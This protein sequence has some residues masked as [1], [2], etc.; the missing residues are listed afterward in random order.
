M[1]PTPRGPPGGGGPHLTEDVRTYHCY[2]RTRTFVKHD[3]KVLVSLQLELDPRLMRR[4]PHKIVCVTS[5]LGSDLDCNC[6]AGR[7]SD[8]V[9]LLKKFFRVICF[10]VE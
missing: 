3:I 6:F 8:K 5:Q 10:F 2:V 4:S 1:C 7:F 9:V